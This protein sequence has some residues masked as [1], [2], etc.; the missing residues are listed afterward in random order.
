MPNLDEI[1]ARIEASLPVISK[2]IADAQVVACKGVEA[3][4]LYRIFNEGEGTTK[5]IGRYKTNKK[6][7]YKGSSQYIEKRKAKGLQTNYKDL[8]YSGDLFNSLQTGS[9]G[10]IPTVGIVNEKSAKIAEYQ[11]EQTGIKI[12]QPTS[13]EVSSNTEKA[14]RFLFDKLGE[15]VQSWNE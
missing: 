1:A 11:E 8:Q 14:R 12:F 15:V 13:E 5:R 9:L 10:G 7:K 3:D 2:A 4:M 6:G